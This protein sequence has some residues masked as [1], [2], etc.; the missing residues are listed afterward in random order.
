M[1]GVKLAG[2]AITI[3]DGALTIE[4]KTAEAT[5][6]TEERDILR[7]RRTG[8]LS[9]R[10]RLPD[11][12]DADRAEPAYEDGVLE[13]TLPKLEAKRPKSIVITS[14]EAK[15]G[16]ETPCKAAFPAAVEEGPAHRW[17]GPLLYWH[18]P[19]RW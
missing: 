6:Q 3:D 18:H 15:R 14:G 12:V 9:R 1:P 17:P 10:L 7:E 16:V 11:T 5:E 8:S 4:G 19:A 2:I 13:I